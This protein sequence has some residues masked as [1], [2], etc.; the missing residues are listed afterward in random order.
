M[1]ISGGT[2]PYLENWYSANPNQLTNGLYYL[3]I[4]D[5]NQCIIDTSFNIVSPS[6]I[7]VQTLNIENNICFGDSLGYITIACLCS[8]LYFQMNP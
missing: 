5:S 4:I 7:N 8:L 6:N 2:Q 3:T 1:N